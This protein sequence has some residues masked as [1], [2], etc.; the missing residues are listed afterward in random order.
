MF[1]V[2][3]KVDYG[4]LLLLELAKKSDSGYVS[5]HSIADKVHLSEKY[6]SQLILL[7]KQAGLVKS[8]EGKGGGYYLARKPK[9]ISLLEVVTALEGPM[10]LVRCLE[11]KGCPAN[12]NCL[13]NPVWAELQQTVQ[14]YF[15]HKTLQDLL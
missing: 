13:V 5:L 7:L 1:V 3:T 9:A 6:L 8:K 4:L 12:H 2:S 11:P 14:K 15:K 10:R